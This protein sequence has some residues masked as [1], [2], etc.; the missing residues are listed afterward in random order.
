LA[1]SPFYGECALASTPF[2][3]D[4]HP[5][6]IQ[7]LTL[8]RPFV[9]KI[10]RV[11]MEELPLILITNDDGVQAEG[12]QAL[13]RALSSV[14]R[15][16]V[17][18][19][20]EERSAC[21]HAIT[22]HRPLRHN[23][24]EPDV[25]SIDGTPADCVALAL[26]GDRFLPRAPD[27]VLSGINHGVNLGTDIFYSGTVAGARE[28]A[29]RGVA[30]MAISSQLGG[31]FDAI[32]V[33]AR[34]M[35]MAVLQAA[36]PVGESVLLNINFPKGEAVGVVTTRLSTRIYESFVKTRRDP[37]GGEYHWIGGSAS[38]SGSCEG[39]DTDA[40]KRGFISVTPLAIEAINPAH[41]ALATSVADACRTQRH[42]GH[43]LEQG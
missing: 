3:V 19:P 28:A 21:G 36:K 35:V 43:A 20:A 4:I 2:A 11:T 25:Y 37:S 33:I 39:S 15:P 6:L 40:I 23:Q 31:V 27:L 24:H 8:V 1:V 41:F 34:K 13:R 38:E 5:S 17:V 30:A 16:V 42:H 26:F 9:A 7:N 29:M 10:I 18:A 22:L 14:A 32:A 12:I